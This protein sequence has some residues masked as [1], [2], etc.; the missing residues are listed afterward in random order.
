M[1]EILA[2][3]RGRDPTARSR[4]HRRSRNRLVDLVDSFVDNIALM[5]GYTKLFNSILASTVWSEPMETRIVW[6]TLL[7]MC[8]RRG[9]VE[10][11]VPGLAVFA[12]L[13]LQATQTA[14]ERLSAPDEFSR[15]KEHEGRRLEVVEGGWR[16]INHAKYRD[17]MGK[18]ERREYLKLKQREYR[19][20]KQPVDSLGDKSTML[21]HTAPAPSPDTTKRDPGSSNTCDP[22]RQL[23]N[24]QQMPPQPTKPN[25]RS[26]HPIFQGQR[27]VVFD[28]MLEDIG[29][30]L[31][32]HLDT[33]DIDAWFYA[34][35]ARAV[36]ENAIKPKD[37]WWPWIQAEL[38]SEA[39]RRG[40]TKPASADKKAREDAQDAEVLRLVKESDARAAQGF[41]K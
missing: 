35:D 4:R 26:K 19:R 8:D 38:I 12:R 34:L 1:K 24:T 11:S 6:I 27:F 31:G 29:R 28:W 7:A 32:S 5:A 39:E 15:S 10:G 22:L 41:G 40:L 33:F 18:D 16:L 3:F 13:P 25:G 20:R 36:A 14:L 37:A 30:I 21:T 2:Q 23:A 9:I 17:K